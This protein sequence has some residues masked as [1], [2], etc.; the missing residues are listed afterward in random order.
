MNQSRSLWPSQE[1]G[2][3]PFPLSSPLL[4]RAASCVSHARRN[5]KMPLGQM[6]INNRDW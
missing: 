6:G 4:C 1:E 5:L 2:E 3:A